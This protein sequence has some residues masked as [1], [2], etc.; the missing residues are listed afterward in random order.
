MT[1]Q[2]QYWCIYCSQLPQRRLE[3]QKE[4]ESHGIEMNWWHSVHARSFGIQSA[5]FG[6]TEIE[7]V[8]HSTNC[9]YVGLTIGWW[10]LWQHLALSNHP[11]PFMCFEDDAIL[12]EDFKNKIEEFAKSLPDDWDIGWAGTTG[13][14]VPE[15]VLNSGNP[16][17]LCA[18]G[19][20]GGTHALLI[21]KRALSTLMKYNHC[22][23]ILIDNQLVKTVLGKLNVYAFWPTLAR[24]G[25]H[26][27]K[28]HPRWCPPSC[29]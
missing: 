1:Q 19:F 23:E 21:Q 13:H 22:A 29:G 2:I 11:G 18:T 10:M 16:F 6:P 4:F 26:I 28:E 9:G 27:D 17:T 3:V 25:S 5:G 8:P 20:P 15:E 7:N 24:Q 12:C 14:H